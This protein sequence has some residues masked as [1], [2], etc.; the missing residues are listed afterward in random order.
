MDETPLFLLTNLEK[1]GKTSMLQIKNKTPKAH[2]L[3][4]IKRQAH[5]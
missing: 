2:R 5:S 1:R 3:T 4:A